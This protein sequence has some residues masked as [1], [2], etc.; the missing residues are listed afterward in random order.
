MMKTL[1]KNNIFTC[2]S[3]FRHFR[4]INNI[5][6]DPEVEALYCPPC[7]DFKRILEEDMEEE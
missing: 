3:C 2:R 1:L 7:L 4:A 5:C 6:Y